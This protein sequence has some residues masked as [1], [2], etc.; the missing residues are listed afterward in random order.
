MAQRRSRLN[1]RALFE[2]RSRRRFR[3]IT[4]KTYNRFDDEDII[5]S[6][7]AKSITSALWSDNTS[8][9]TTFFTSSTQ[10][11]SAAGAYQYEVY[12][13]NPQTN[14]SASV[15]FN[16]AWGHYAGSGSKTGSGASDQGNTPS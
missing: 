12:E 4:T 9:L 13:D 8:T 2:A 15:Q 16:I 5:E 11:A 10:T 1:K 6:D 7:V 3:G 14:A